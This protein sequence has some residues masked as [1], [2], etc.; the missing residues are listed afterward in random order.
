MSFRTARIA[1]AMLVIFIAAALA[2]CASAVSFGQALQQD[3]DVSVAA[4]TKPDS[5][6][7]A[8]LARSRSTGFEVGY[9][10]K[11][12]YLWDV[13]GENRVNIVPLDSGTVVTPDSTGTP[14][15]GGTPAEVTR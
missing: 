14:A 11:C 13:F 5:I 2:S 1:L 10:P 7:I 12:L 9:G 15:T 6:C 3:A 8:V 4:F